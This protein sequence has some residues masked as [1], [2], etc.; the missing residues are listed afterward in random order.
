[1]QF[2]TEYASIDKIVA[3]AVSD[4]DKT[5]IIFDPLSL[6]MDLS[7]CDAN[8]CKLDFEKL[9]NFPLFDFYHD[10]CGIQKHINRVT[11]DLM[12]CFSPRCSV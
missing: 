2:S 11:G 8:G 10:L 6:T 9:L 4:S 3:R 7:A 12:D 5:G 1:M